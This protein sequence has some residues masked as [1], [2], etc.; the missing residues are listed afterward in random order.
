MDARTD[1]LLD[2]SKVLEQLGSYALSDA[3]QA[4]CLRLRPHEEPAE[5]EEDRGLL[6]EALVCSEEILGCLQSFPDIAGVFEFLGGETPLDEDGLWG[7]KQ[8]LLQAR[9]AHSVL[10]SL[11]PERQPRLASRLD[12]LSWPDKTWQGIHRCL[13]D[14]GELRDESSPELM[15]T[16][17]EVRRLHNQCTKKI[18]EFVEE[19]NISGFLQD[20][21]LT[22][23]SD[24]YVLS[25]KSNFKGRLSGI[26]HDYSQ[27][28]E[29]CYFEP[30]FLVELNNKLQELK[31]QEREAKRRVLLYLTSLLGQEEE[32]IKRLYE[33]LVELDVL[34]AK[35][36][37][38]RELDGTPLTMAPGNRLSIRKARHPLLLWEKDHVEPVDIE[39]TPP[40]KALIIT[41]GNS[42]GK[43][44]CLKTLGLLALMAKSALP[45]PADRDSSAPFWSDIFVFMGDEQSLQEHVSTFTAQIEYFKEVWPRIGENSLVLLDE[46]GAGTDPS[47]GAALAQAVMDSLLQRGG[48]VVAATHFPALKAYAM[49]R[50]D[51]RAASVLFDPSTKQPLY[52]L[53]YDQAG[54]S[55]ALDVAK[56]HGLPEE[57]LE[58]AEQYLLLDGEDTSGLLNRLNELAVQREQELTDLHEEQ[59][60]LQQKKR[61]MQD[62]YEK[63]ISQA[64]EEVR[65]YSQQIL[66]QWKQ[67]RIGRKQAQK[68]LGEKRKELAAQL[69]RGE[70]A[71][72]QERDF[73]PG[74]KVLYTPWSRSGRIEEKDE[75]KSRYKIDL[76]GVSIWAGQNELS[77]EEGSGAK[78]GKSFAATRVKSEP[79]SQLYL[80]LRGLRAEEAQ[81]E[82]ARFLDQ[83]VY[84]GREEAEIIHGRG[85]GMLRRAVHDYLRD[86]PGVRSFS[87]APEDRGGDG[88][89]LIELE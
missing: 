63:R 76:G 40:Q 66:Q 30:L 58:R 36:V 81:A 49:A 52:R 4:V 75:K 68:R 69:G 88:V 62:K 87:L 84:Q 39:L 14:A 10:A 73:E 18:G 59:K 26:I 47:Q 1:R 44:V 21:Y 50:E 11:D 13:D 31:Q 67:D 32:K 28:G 2:F 78:S 56:E 54:S 33:W 15:Q 65:G 17:T 83:A 72:Q 85:T 22:I 24:R 43:T 5:L 35:V 45:V 53:A 19:K 51:V 74:E 3:G 25:L 77:P 64:I 12:T 48:W 9:R 27:S 23:S 34:R 70:E 8:V 61:E 79:V 82:L 89:T 60:H 41:G 16:R 46:F 86:F 55:Q 7:V 37:M 57:V 71:E 42:G 6:S 80:D 20:D 38:A 29:T